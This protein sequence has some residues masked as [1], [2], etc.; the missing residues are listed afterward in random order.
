[1]DGYCIM[2]TDEGTCF[3]YEMGK[4]EAKHESNISLLNQLFDGQGDK[5]ARS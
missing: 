4:K 2:D 1:M 5:I 3:L